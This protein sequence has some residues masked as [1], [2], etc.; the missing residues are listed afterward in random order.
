MTAVKSQED[1]GKGSRTEQ[2]SR[3][4]LKGY[5]QALRTLE[6]AT[7]AVANLRERTA[8]LEARKR[9]PPR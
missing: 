1:A 7:E 4:R 6:Q 9:L 8:G 2:D 3:D 5:R